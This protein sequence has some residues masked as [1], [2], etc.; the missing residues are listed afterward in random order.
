MCLQVRK[1]VG[2]PRIAQVLKVQGSKAGSAHPT[3]AQGSALCP[4]NRP[5]ICTIT[6]RYPLLY[7]L[8]RYKPLLRYHLPY[9]D[10]VQSCII[11][12]VYISGSPVCAIQ[13]VLFIVRH[14]NLPVFYSADLLTVCVYDACMLHVFPCFLCDFVNREEQASH[15]HSFWGSLVTGSR[16]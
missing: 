4:W 9:K 7:T 13:C 11:I 10:P 5:S 3:G 8:Y 15:L 14:A 16:R 2:S 12:H 1:Q 6:L